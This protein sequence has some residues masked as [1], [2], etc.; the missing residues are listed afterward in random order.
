MYHPFHPFPLIYTNDTLCVALPKRE[1][2][3][4]S[5]F[6]SVYTHSQVSL[7]LFFFSFFLSF[8]SLFPFCFLSSLSP[9]HLCV[10]L[11][12]QISF[13]GQI[14]PQKAQ[15][16]FYYPPLLLLFLSVFLLPFLKLIPS[17]HS[18]IPQTDRQTEREQPQPMPSIWSTPKIYTETKPPPTCPP[19]QKQKRAKRRAKLQSTTFK[20]QRRNNE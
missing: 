11:L 5:C 15:S 10:P 2:S 1:K 20:Q 7:S 16:V 12:R 19:P 9:S 8:P 17:F 6:A 4:T 3:S 13:H 18:F 14:H